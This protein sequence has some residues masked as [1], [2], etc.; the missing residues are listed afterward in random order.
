MWVSVYIFFMVYGTRNANR[1]GFSLL[2]CS[3]SSQ[4][5]CDEM[6]LLRYCRQ[7]A[8]SGTNIRTANLKFG[9]MIF[10]KVGVPI[11]FTSIVYTCSTFNGMRFKHINRGKGT[12]KIKPKPTFK[13]RHELR[14][15]LRSLQKAI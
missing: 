4:Q 10:E 2:H 5:P 14:P 13:S 8:I 15:R 11:L 6:Q 7:K 12:V 1:L 9:Q 3:S